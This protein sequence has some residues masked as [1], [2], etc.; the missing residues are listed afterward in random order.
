MKISYDLT[1]FNRVVIE[2]EESKLA[3]IRELKRELHLEYM[4]LAKELAP[5]LRESTQSVIAMKLE[6][7]F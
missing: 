1:G 7:V 4:K 3:R 2:F 6:D 5:D